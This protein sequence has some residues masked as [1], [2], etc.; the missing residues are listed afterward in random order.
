MCVFPRKCVTCSDSSNY[1][2]EKLPFDNDSESLGLLTVLLIL[3]SDVLGP[4]W[5]SW[6]K[7]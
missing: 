4:S 1:K 6:E 5:Y 3:F 7:W 2:A